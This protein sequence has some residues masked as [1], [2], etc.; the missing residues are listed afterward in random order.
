MK[1]KPLYVLVGPT[2]SG[3][4]GTAI[5]IAKLI[6]KNQSLNAEIISADSIQIYKSLDIGSAKPNKT[7]M[8]GIV[9][10][11]LDFVDYKDPS[12]NVALFRNRAFECI[13]DIYDR[14]GIPIVVGGTGLY[15]NSL[16]FPLTFTNVLP[17]EERRAELNML[18]TE[19]PGILHVML[20]KF[21]PETASKLHPNDTKRIIRAIE[22]FEQSGQCLSEICNDFSNKRNV[23]V[24]YEPIMAGINFERSLLY[25]RIEQRIDKMLA[26][27]FEDEVKNILST[28]PD[29]GLPA[30]QAL[31]YKQLTKYLDG[32]YSYDEAVELMKRDTRRFAKR[33]ISWFKRDE[34]IKWFDADD[35]TI[36]CLSSGIYRYFFE[37][38]S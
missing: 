26:D 12:Y 25:R 15:I 34:R 24:D 30:L 33:Q 38:R 35:V 6:K 11:M 13:S 14:E 10:H 27:G 5:E 36:T 8:Q 23:E 32:E 22:V 7:E 2:A 31:G 21:D 37:T 17:N 18:E 19:S 4:T 9:H 29:R 28:N 16:V 3:K 20:K 1:K